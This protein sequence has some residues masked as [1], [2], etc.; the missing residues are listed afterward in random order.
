MSAP[1]PGGGG[2]QGLDA[3]L[4]LLLAAVRDP[5]D[6]ATVD[7][8]AGEPG[9]PLDADR[10][11]ALARDPG[12]APLAYRGLRGL[13][14][15]LPAAAVEAL[16]VEAHR[17]AASSL[18][19]VRRLREVLAALEAAGVPA[20]A[21]KGPAQAALAYGDPGL[22]PFTDLDLLVREPDLE[23][24]AAA[25]EAEGYRPLVPSARARRLHRVGHH[26]L[27]LVAPDGTLVELHWDVLSPYTGWTIP[28][29]P[30]WDRASGV[31]LGGAEIPTLSAEDHALVVCAHSAKHHWERLE[32]LTSLAG[33]L[34][35]PG[36]DPAGVLARS[37][38]TGTER[39]VLLGAALAAA[40]LE[41]PLPAPL[42]RGLDATPSVAPLVEAVRRWLAAPDGPPVRYYH[43]RAARFHLRLRDSPR[44]RLR[45][46]GRAVGQLLRPQAEDV[47]ALALPRGLGAGYYLVRPVRLA[48]EAL[49]RPGEG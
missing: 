38:E 29:A 28:S 47:E 46:V 31:R 20:L 14:A 34:R 35:A 8:I 7:R 27:A 36:V 26:D 30:L 10:F 41:A 11:V 21:Y 9:R 3:E 1:A 37:R 42:R 16:R 43:P 19:L 33:L 18:L 13:E 4:R 6:A 32:W 23:A 2:T 17:S 24:A 5:P 15:P 22:R 12:L 40:L 44:D 49:R 48:L 45:F 25:L 39:T